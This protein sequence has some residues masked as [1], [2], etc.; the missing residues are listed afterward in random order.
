[1]C[2]AP[3]NYTP[4]E[5]RNQMLEE[6]SLINSELEPMSSSSS[7]KSSS[8]SSTSVQLP[9]PNLPPPLSVVDA[10]DAHAEPK[11]KNSMFSYWAVKDNSVVDVEELDARR[12]A[13][14]KINS[15]SRQSLFVVKTKSYKITDFPDK[16]DFWQIIGKKFSLKQLFYLLPKGPF[17][18]PAPH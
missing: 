7:G 15:E 4:Q 1:V 3:S 8:S 18:L 16:K 6:K 14:A 5:K 17:F 10:V 11:P 12:N 2:V 9:P 13:D